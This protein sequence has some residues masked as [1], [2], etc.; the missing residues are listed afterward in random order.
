MDLD[1]KNQAPE[2][3]TQ[4]GANTATTPNLHLYFSTYVKGLG[5][6]LVKVQPE[7]L[8]H[9][10]R[11][12]NGGAC[13][14]L[15]LAKFFNAS[16]SRT[17]EAKS[18][19]HWLFALGVNRRVYELW[20]ARALAIGLMTRRDKWW[21]DLT[22]NEKCYDIL[23]CR[24]ISEQ[25]PLMPLKALVSKGW[26]AHVWGLYVAR[27]EGRPISQVALRTMTGVS[28]RNQRQYERQAG[29]TK[30]SNIAFDLTRRGDQLAGT[31][32]FEGNNVFVY[33]GHLAR[34]LPNSRHTNGVEYAK[35]GRNKKIQKELNRLCNNEARDEKVVL[36]IYHPTRE[37]LKATL[38]KIKRL[39]IQ[40]HSVPDWLFL[41]SNKGHIWEAV[42]V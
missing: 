24:H 7:V 26:L 28:E 6:E 33:N 31:K 20:L 25:R 34:R 4:G 13:R 32:E 37:S 19:R 38:N 42:R 17:I 2:E 3:R 5:D 8:L 36:R 12:Q 14:L 30:T 1:I 39:S 40:G 16:G 23:G 10:A 18:F 41:Q 29:I 21:L 15:F 35:T 9:A 22:A 27:F 11:G